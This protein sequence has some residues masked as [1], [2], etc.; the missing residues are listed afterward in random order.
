L[1]GVHEDAFGSERDVFLF[2]ESGGARDRDG[3]G[4]AAVHSFARE[5]VGRGEAPGAVCDHADADA[6]GFAFGERADPTV[7]CGDIAMADV[8]DARVGV[9]G[10]S[11][12]GGFEGRMG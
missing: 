3:F 2:R 7:F 6:E 10:A 8:H 11:A 5:A 9:S 12:L 4:G 1:P